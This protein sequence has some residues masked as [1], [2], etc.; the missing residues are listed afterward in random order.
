MIEAVIG[1]LLFVI[2]GLNYSSL[3]SKGADFINYMVKKLSIYSL[4]G[5]I[6]LGTQGVFG[7]LIAFGLDPFYHKV[8]GFI[9]VELAILIINLDTVL[10]HIRYSTIRVG[11]ETFEAIVYVTVIYLFLDKIHP[12]IK[13][14]EVVIVVAIL[15]V[16][17]TVL[18]IYFWEYCR[19]MHM[20]VEFLDLRSPSKIFAFGSMV[21]SVC[22]ILADINSILTLGTLMASMITYLIMCLMIL[23]TL[24]KVKGEF[25]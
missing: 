7:I 23:R 18:T 15:T 11:K 5:A 9:F 8:V 22:G 21:F 2:A 19:I 14:W 3:H 4:L 20:L 13:H 1:L 12:H 17:L 25:H 10:L 24:H 16:I 6:A